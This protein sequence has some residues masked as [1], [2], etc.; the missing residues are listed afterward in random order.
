MAQILKGADVARALDQRTIDL[1]NSLKASGVVPT[2]GILRIGERP[3]DLSYERGAKKRCE[4][5]GVAVK[6]VALS[7]NASQD[8]ILAEIN[9][10]NHDDEIH[11]ILMFRPLPEGVDE[12]V[13]CEAIVP[14]KD[15]DAATTSSLAKVFTSRGAGF[16]PC[17]AQACME[18]LDYYQIPLQG[19]RACVLGRSLVVGKPV[20]QLLMAA[21]ATVT[22]CHSKTSDP[23]TI[24]QNSDIIVVATGRMETVG[25]DYFSP[26][27]TVIDVGINWHDEKC[28]LCGDVVF[29]EAEPIVNALTPV[30]G[31]VGSVTTAVLVYHVAEAALQQCNEL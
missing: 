10:L 20:A 5:A 8:E 6:T 14:E 29:E 17:T 30:P 31:G 4:G 1:V 18:I 24:A 21:N 16:I 27:Q 11:G 25:A 9:L 23:A 2:L 28:K 19:Q 7:D 13:C 3:D 15:V 22:V 26:G 12:L